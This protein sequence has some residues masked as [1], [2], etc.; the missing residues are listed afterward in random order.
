MNADAA[1]Y[2]DHLV[3][4]CHGILG[5]S[6]DLKYFSD[7]LESKGFI[8]LRSSAN[9]W[10]KSLKGLK[11]AA[12]N[13]KEEITKWKELHPTL[14][15]VSFIGN[16]LGGLIV[17]YAIHL[18]YDNATGKMCDME[19]IFLLVSCKYFIPLYSVAFLMVSII[20]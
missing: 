4:L 15:K 5:Y 6:L 8:V 14:K 1:S 16:S 12:E 3:V 7:Q 2:K 20:C 13:V 17:R 9:E 18:L 19:P 11:A 10:D